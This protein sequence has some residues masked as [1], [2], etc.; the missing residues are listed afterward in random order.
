MAIHVVLVHPEI[1]W[2][3][4][5]AGRNTERVPGLNNWD[6]NL[7]KNVRINERVST[8]FRTE[9]YNIWN[10]PQY[11]YRSVGP[12]VP[13]EGTI[14]SSVQT[15]IAGRFVNPQALEAG[16]RIIRYQLSLRF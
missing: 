9:F 16:G 1:H 4:G 15:S 11:G 14:A 2:N 3:T 13:G 5:N 7:S 6:V 12:F 10:H 8:E